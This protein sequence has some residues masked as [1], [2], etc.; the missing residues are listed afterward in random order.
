ML[1]WKIPTFRHTLTLPPSYLKIH[2]FVVI[3]QSPA[4]AVS[5][6]ASAGRATT[7]SQQVRTPIVLRC[8][9]DGLELVSRLHSGPNAEHRQLE[10]DIKD[11]PVRGATGHVAH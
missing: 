2:S 7:S 4:P 9:S 11:S 3:F 1:V 8:S 6:S 10:I 5:H